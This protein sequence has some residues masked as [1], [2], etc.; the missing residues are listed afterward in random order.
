MSAS[1][2]PRFVQAAVI[3]VEADIDAGESANRALSEVAA[4]FFAYPFDAPESLLLL[5]GDKGV[6]E[7][8]VISRR[9]R[10]ENGK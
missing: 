4:P 9:L 5:Y 7:Q 10:I 2:A 1:S 3:D 8:E 6:G